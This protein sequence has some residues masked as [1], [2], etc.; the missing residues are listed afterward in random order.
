M[1]V[2]YDGWAAAYAPN[3]PAALHLFDLLSQRPAFVEP[4][5][6]LPGAGGGAEWLPEDVAVHVLPLEDTAANRLRWEQRLLPGMQRS[7]SAA[8]LHTMSLAAPLFGAPPMV[9]SPASFA[10]EPPVP[11]RGATARLRLALAQ[12]ARRPRQAVLWPQDLALPPAL[13]RI[14]PLPPLV[15]P[16]FNPSEAPDRQRLAA[17]GATRP[18]VLYHGP[19]DELTLRWVLAAWSWVYAAL[20]EDVC[21]L[22]LDCPPSQASALMSQ[23]DGLNLGESVY[24]VPAQPPDV[25]ASLYRGCRALFHPAGS[26]PWGGA[27]RYALSCGKP[28]VALET[29]LTDALTGPAAYLV[30]ERD[31]RLLGAALLSVLVEERLADSLRRA[32]LERVRSWPLTRFSERLGDSYRKVLGAAG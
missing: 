11:R 29:S 3:S 6:A 14:E 12:G 31:T 7:L 19:K 1:R 27:L 8:L 13:G 5:V 23:L 18:Y 32:A 16:D 22:M 25:V 9:I 26:V 15:P 30:P 4:V 21:L 2:L 28:V 10:G 24:P 20:G 17:L